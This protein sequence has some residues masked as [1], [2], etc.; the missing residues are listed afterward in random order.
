MRYF[1]AE[2]MPVCEEYGVNMCVHPDDPPFQ[3]LGLPRIVTCEEDIE[4]FLGAV[5]NPH[6]G[7]TFC[8]YVK[9][10]PTSVLRGGQYDKLM[11]R[12]GRRSNACGFAVY[13]DELD[14]LPEQNFSER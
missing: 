2:I 14:R 8:G 13:L 1:L 10:V 3:V 11:R 4:W 12:M 5:D 9:D 7:L 6:N